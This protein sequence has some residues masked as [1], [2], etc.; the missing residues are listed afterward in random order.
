VQARIAAA[1]TALTALGMWALQLPGLGLLS[2]FVFL[3]S[4]IPI[5]GVA[6]STVPIGFVALTEYGFF[7]VFPPSP[8][9]K[10]PT[11]GPLLNNKLLVKHQLTN[12]ARVLPVLDTATIHKS[13]HMQW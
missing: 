9:N 8:P 2:V 7:K 1:N 12:L 13:S 5:A 6:I 4:F 3:C 11:Y 10:S